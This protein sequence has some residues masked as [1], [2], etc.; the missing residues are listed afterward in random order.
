MKSNIN[1]LFRF[2]LCLS[3]SI[4]V[5]IA[6]MFVMLIPG[7]VGSYFNSE[8]LELFLGLLV[9]LAFFCYLALN[10]YWIFNEEVRGMFLVHISKILFALL[11]VIGTI[12]TAGIGLLFTFP[13]LVFIGY[14][15]Y[16]HSQKYKEYQ[17][18]I[19]KNEE[20]QEKIR[21]YNEYEKQI[22]EYERYQARL[23]EKLDR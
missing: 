3:I 23:K 22:E 15:L 14:L 6:F 19:K 2:I 4:S 7:L 12:F 10:L 5:S 21:K 1:K 16:W 20:D 11:V 13:A 17:D 18:K 9:G 8:S